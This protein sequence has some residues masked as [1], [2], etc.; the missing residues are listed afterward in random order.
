MRSLA[1]FIREAFINSKKNF[2]TT[3]GA[4]VTIFLSLFVIGI[5]MLLS[6]IIDQIAESVE[7]QVAITIYLHDDAGEAD[8]AIFE[9]LINKLPDVSSIYYVSKDEA[10]KRFR[11]MS[12]RTAATADQLDGNPLPANLEVS[13]KDPEKVGE[14]AEQI[15]ANEYFLK[16]IDSPGDP[17]YSLKYGRETVDKLFS[18][19]NGIRIVCAVLDA[20]LIL[21]ALIFIN[22]TIRLAILARRKEIA[23]MRLVGASNGFIRGPFLMEGSLQAIVGAGMAIGSIALICNYLFPMLRNLIPWL[24]LSTSN[25]SIWMIY[26]VLLGAGLVIGLFGSGWAMRRY[27]RV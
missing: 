22:N 10:M 13:L 25:I 26:L 9:D 6:L 2:S 24:P 23:I 17:N 3:L 19:T 15:M 4:V 1:Y 18:V 5:F 8:V 7:S 21:V 11:E 16:V 14:V 27:L 12:D 20:L